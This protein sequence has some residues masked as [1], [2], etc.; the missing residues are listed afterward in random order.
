MKLTGGGGGEREG[1]KRDGTPRPGCATTI[2]ILISQFFHAAAPP[3]F[4]STREDIRV[5]LFDTLCSANGTTQNRLSVSLK[6]KYC[7]KNSL[8]E[9][10]T[11]IYSNF[12]GL[13][14]HVSTSH[15]YD[16]WWLLNF[17]V[18][19]LWTNVKMKFLLASLKS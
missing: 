5:F 9:C 19:F 15:A 17:F 12:E 13:E 14:N 11:S 4:G 8:K 1:A 16:C 18:A 6:R 7:N 3:E 10:V 2:F